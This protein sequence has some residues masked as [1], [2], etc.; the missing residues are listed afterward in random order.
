MKLV[1]EIKSQT[2]TLHFQRYLLFSTPF[3]NCYLHK[4]Y[5][6]DQDIHFHSHPWSFAG[7][8]LKGS[9]LEENNNGL[10]LRSF[11]SLGY[12]D[13]RYFHKI[14]KVLSPVTSLFFTG[15]KTY[16]WGYQTSEGFIPHEQYRTLKRDGK[17]PL[18]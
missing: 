15:K 3:F 13:R 14:K 1:K 8:I 16:E 9:Y 5:E 12:G 6:G 11:G 4:I 2:G 10:R 7:L 17:L 18:F